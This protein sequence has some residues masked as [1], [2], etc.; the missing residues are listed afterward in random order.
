[1]Q[2]YSDTT[3]L[4]SEKYIFFIIIIIMI[5]LNTFLPVPWQQ[6]KKDTAP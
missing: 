2:N 3:N 1:M 6:H 5:H 4:T